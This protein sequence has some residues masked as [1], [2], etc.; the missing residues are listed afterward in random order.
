MKNY[1]IKFNL[2]SS[3]RNL[4]LNNL[5]FV[6]FLQFLIVELSLAQD[7]DHLKKDF[8]RMGAM[9]NTVVGVELKD[10]DAAFKIWTDVL[11]KK[12][13]AK[14]LYDFTFEYKMYE[15][16]D[17][18]KNDI[19]TGLINYFNVPVQD[20]FYL[21]LGNNF[22]P[23]LSGTNH[24]KQKFTYYYLVTSSKNKITD[25]KELEGKK[26]NISKSITDQI[27][28]IWLKTILRDEMGAK[29][30]KSVNLQTVNDNENEDLLAVFF[31][32]TDYALVSQSTFDLASELNPSLLKKIQIIRSSGNLVT[33]L[34]VYRKGMNSNTIKVIKDIV[35]DLHNDNEGRQILNLFKISKIIPIDKDDLTECEKVINKY[36]K[37]FK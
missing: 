33:G 6:L 21:N 23:F 7:K 35:S 8:V 18:L 20:Y 30:Y 1:S 2:V 37:Y 3:I 16:I 9:T 12:F 10:A 5:Y 34:F 14:N 17:G 26:V 4:I 22:I 11:V 28:A 24:P 15:N 27:G 13:K 29:L 36:N 19:R 31:N 25:L 32:K